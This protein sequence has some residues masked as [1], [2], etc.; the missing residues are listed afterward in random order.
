MVEATLNEKVLKL[1]TTEQ[2]ATTVERARELAKQK[3]EDLQGK[4]G[5]AKLKLAEAVSIV[6]AYDKELA[7][8]KDTINVTPQTRYPDL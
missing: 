7:N 8:L 4:L 6:T 5:G 3:M 2:S 1:A